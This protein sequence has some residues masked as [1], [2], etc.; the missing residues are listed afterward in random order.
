MKE[1][2]KTVYEGGIGEVVM[3]KSKFIA[4][5]CPVETEDAANEIIEKLKKKYWDATHNCSAYIIG[6]ENPLMRCSDD[7]EPSKTA[8]RPML[9]VLIAHELTNLVVVVTRYFGGTL[10]GTGGLVKAYQSATIEGLNQSKLIVKELGLQLQII[11]D[12][13][14]IGKIQYY[15]GQEQITLLSSEYTDFVKLVL[16]VPPSK[17]LNVTKKIAELTNGSAILDELEQVYFATIDSE[18]RLF[19]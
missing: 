17:I 7:G 19:R 16:L 3:K 6:T 14:L 11:T 10:L 2:F 1:I 12:Y 13:N 5:V 8:G 15:V 9:D 18:V 4:T